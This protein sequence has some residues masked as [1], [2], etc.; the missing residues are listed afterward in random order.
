MNYQS[1]LE[2][3]FRLQRVGIKLGLDNILTLLD[4]LDNPQTQWPAIHIA[5]TNGKGSTG[6][7]VASI[8]QQN[9]LQVGFYTSPHLIDFTERIRVN[10]QFIST[11]K[12][13]ELTKHLRPLIEKI[14]PSFFEVTTAMAFWYFAEKNVDVAVIETG[15]GGRLDSTNVVNPL[16]TL[17]TPI[18]F[19]HQ[20]FLGN[21]IEEIASEKAGI[22]KPGVPCLTNNRQP[23]VLEA[24]A[25]KCRNIGAE[26]I[27]ANDAGSY[28]INQLGLTGSRCN[29]EICGN[30]F[31]EIAV[32]LP[33]KHQVENALLAL[34]TILE[35]K[36]RLPV[37]R[38]AIVDGM[39]NLQWRGRIHQVS[40]NP[41]IIIDVSHNPSGFASTFDFLRKFFQK[42]R[43]RA[44]TFLQNDKDFS[45]I[46]E[47]LVDNVH[48][49][50]IVDLKMGKPLAPQ[51]LLNSIKN[52][53]GVGWIFP[54]FESI[55]KEIEENS[56]D[57][58]WL[59][60]GSHYLAGEAYRYFQKKLNIEI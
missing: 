13:V 16:A 28:E 19:D 47:I 12:I 5:G 10:Q 15:L 35:I 46:G 1:T 53:G 51:S 48:D 45:K 52:R 58:L 2:Y 11:Q 25:E 4:A 7:M 56:D 21:S 14:E 20:N 18:D 33:G 29:F 8:L 50:R 40:E 31:E 43:I 3:L 9:G 37:S 54:T 59:I 49:I 42:D 32:N 44:I 17:I 34:S 6:A 23:A 60:I 36:D 41:R 38:Q 22:I 30:Y 55:I 27:N 57:H 39:A 24:L 26:L